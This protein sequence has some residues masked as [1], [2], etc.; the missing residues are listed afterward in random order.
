MANARCFIC[1]SPTDFDKANP[2]DVPTLEDTEQWITCP[3]CGKYGLDHYLLRNPL[4]SLGELA[5]FVSA[6]TR[7]ASERGRPV[8][9]NQSTKFSTIAEPYRNSSVSQ[10]I[11]KLLRTI[12]ERCRRPGQKATLSPARDY[13][14]ADCADV[15]EFVSYLMHLNDSKLINCPGGNDWSPTSAGWQVLEPTVRP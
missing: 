3:V 1:G 5:P 13:P 10:K 9:L 14:L 15:S 11:E 2:P 6:A 4:L 12:A 8:E 7:Q